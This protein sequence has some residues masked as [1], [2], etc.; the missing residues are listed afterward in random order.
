MKLRDPGMTRIRELRVIDLWEIEN[1]ENWWSWE[2]QVWLTIGLKFQMYT[3]T[4]DKCIHGLKNL[5]QA[6]LGLNP[7]RTQPD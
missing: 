7:S 4:E 3:W 1:G 5:I 2:V 6:E